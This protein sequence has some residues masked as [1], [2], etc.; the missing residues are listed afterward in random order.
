[1]EASEP[2]PHEAS[3]SVSQDVG[4]VDGGVQL[5][6]NDFPDHGRRR[7]SASAT[8][9]VVVTGD[10]NASS[11][12]QFGSRRRCCCCFRCWVGARRLSRVN[13]TDGTV[14]ET[15][16]HHVTATRGAKREE[17][18]GKDVA[19]EL[20]IKRDPVPVGNTSRAMQRGGAW[21]SGSARERLL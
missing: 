4:V 20:P 13:Q 18:D 12:A 15:A 21:A 3:C 17:A 11:R 9:T 1:M 10:V 19:C 6:R 5:D 2:V 16:D 8:M 7:R 14:A